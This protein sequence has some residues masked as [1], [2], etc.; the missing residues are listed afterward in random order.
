MFIPKEIFEK[1]SKKCQK[2]LKEAR[3]EIWVDRYD[4]LGYRGAG[5]NSGTHKLRGLNFEFSYKEDSEFFTNLES[6]AIKY[7]EKLSVR[8]M[9]KELRE[10]R[11]LKESI[12]HIKGV[13]GDI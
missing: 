13:V 6:T 12:Q 3:F 11:K 2:E 9:E 8:E 1:L 4:Q 10:L 7:S 5:F